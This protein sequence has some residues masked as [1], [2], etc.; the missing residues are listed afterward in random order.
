MAW[1]Y[2]LYSDQNPEAMIDRAA[3]SWRGLTKYMTNDSNAGGLWSCAA[4]L[5]SSM[6]ASST[7]SLE[8]MLFK[9][10]S[11]PAYDTIS[12]GMRSPCWSRMGSPREWVPNLEPS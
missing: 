10:C 2:E 5:L 11:N 6:P 4:L 12:K 3:G 1:R 7:P 9:P 8:Q